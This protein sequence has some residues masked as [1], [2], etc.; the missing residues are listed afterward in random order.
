MTPTSLRI[1]VAGALLLPVALAAQTTSA[2][3]MTLDQ[4]RA[5]ARPRMMALD[6]N[7]DGRI[8]EKE[9]EARPGAPKA[10]GRRAKLAG[11][12]FGRLDTND[13]GALDSGEMD[14]M[15]AKR[16]ER[17]DTDGNGTL[18]AAEREAA[19]GRLE[20]MMDRG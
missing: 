8:S 20:G 5:A 2:D 4:F 13:D 14:A 6:S 1:C 19:R 18:S 17:M 15:L 3:G 7:G 10:T 11:R 9:F 12:I 16:F